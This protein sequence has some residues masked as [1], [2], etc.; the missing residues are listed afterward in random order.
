MPRKSTWT[1]KFVPTSDGKVERKCVEASEEEGVGGARGCARTGVFLQDT[2]PAAR[3]APTP[4]V[5]GL[6]EPDRPIAWLFRLRRSLSLFVVVWIAANG[7]QTAE[8]AVVRHHA[9]V[10]ADRLDAPDATLE[11]HWLQLV[12]HALDVHQVVLR[13]DLADAHPLGLPRMLERVRPS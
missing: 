10:L 13:L 6:A 9:Q 3:L 4:Q 8:T 11:R 2:A 1:S 12:E 5:V 7:E